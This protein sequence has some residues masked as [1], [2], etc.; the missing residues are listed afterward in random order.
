MAL[1]IG[2]AYH[3][4][5]AEPSFR[6]LRYFEALAEDLHFARAAGRLHIS[7][8]S[9]SQQI[10]RLEAALG[11]RLFART[12]RSVRLTAAGQAL[13]PEA[14]QLLVQE[15]RM[16]A[17]VHRVAEGQAGELRVGFVAS[18]AY[19]LLPSILRR[20]RARHPD[21]HLEV[22]ECALRVP[23]E[24]LEAGTLDVAIVRGPIVRGP[25]SPPALRVETLLLEPLCAVLPRDHPLAARTPLRVSALHAEPFALFPRERA[26]AFH[27]AIL[28]LCRDA[29]FVPRIVHEA[30]D[31]QVLVSMVAAGLA[32]T[33][34]PVSVRQLP[35]AGVVYRPLRPARAVAELDLV[36]APERASPLVEAFARVAREIAAEEARPRRR[37]R[38]GRA[39]ARAR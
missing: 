19:D 35:R 21:V 4:P 16:R 32:V 2:N 30:A 37:R 34:A 23:V 27:D 38:S 20:F 36:Y 11:A 10:Q 31:W 13:L 25:S 28:G 5:M 8:P 7:Q 15:D 22:D 24:Q 14:R 29:G 6:S 1:E 26:P 17:H 12:R 9:L 33:L 18:G 3:G 39:Q